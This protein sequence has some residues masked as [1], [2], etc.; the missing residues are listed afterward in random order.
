MGIHF[1]KNA[2]ND[3]DWIIQKRL[4]NAAWLNKLLPAVAPLSTMR[5]ITSSTWALT[6]DGNSSE[7]F[8]AS[9]YVQAL[10]AVLRLGRAG[11]ST[12]HS[13]V[14]FDVD[15]DTGVVKKGL[16][17]AHWYRLGLQNVLTCPWLPPSITHEKHPDPPHAMVLGT[18]V[19]NIK[20]ALDICI[21]YA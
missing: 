12:D 7:A 14:L 11:A 20:Q 3:G 21:Q 19:P 15:Q 8:R 17:N 10:T 5:V 4:G 16:T 9:D 13:S 18:E 1:F 6:H 2:L